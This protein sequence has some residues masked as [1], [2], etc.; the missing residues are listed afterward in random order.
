[1]LV[2]D[3]GFRY[4]TRKLG[5][6]MESSLV[7]IIEDDMDLRDLCGECLRQENFRVDEVENGTQA[8]EYL[9]SDQIPQ[10]ILM[11]LSVPGLPVPEFMKKL[12]SN[13]KFEKV[14]VI[15]LSGWH[16][17]EKHVKQ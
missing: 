15:I 4:N 3:F 11:D 2:F 5:G 9:N 6:I 13:P 17:L 7:L 1:M 10:V 8:F 12:R 14:P 16:D